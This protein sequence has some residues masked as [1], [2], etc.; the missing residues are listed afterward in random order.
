M[1]IV[2]REGTQTVPQVVEGKE[3]LGSGTRRL[4]FERNERASQLD[5]ARQVFVQE[6]VGEVE[7]VR[8]GDAGPAL[9]IGT[10]VLAQD[11]AVAAYDLFGIGVPYDKLLAGRV[12]RIELVDVEGEPGAAAGKTEGDFAQ[13]SYFAHGIGCVV[14]I[15]NVYF[16]S[17]LA[18]IPHKSVGGQFRLDEFFVNRRDNR[19]HVVVF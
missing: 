4:V 12:H 16:V 7:E 17:A 9:L 5:G 19:F 18:G 13:S 14:T 10:D 11:E 2:D 6:L 3:A 15:D 8:G 1:R